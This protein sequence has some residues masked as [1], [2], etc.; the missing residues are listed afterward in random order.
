M[1]TEAVVH[2]VLQKMSPE[3]GVAQLRPAF[4]VIVR[5]VAEAADIRTISTEGTQIDHC[6]VGTPRWNIFRPCVRVGEVITTE[7]VGAD[8]FSC[9]ER[10]KGYG[11]D[12]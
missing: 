3:T 6:S 9:L 7:Y 11:L 12:R 10:L 8:F 2:A 4:D 1:S 5:R